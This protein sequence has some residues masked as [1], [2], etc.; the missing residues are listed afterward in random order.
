MDVR[1][2]HPYTCL[3][4]GPTS[5]GKKQ[6]V[7]ALIEEGQHMTNGSAEKILCL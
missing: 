6:F 1:H 5:C 3:V 4:A 2:Q 7:K